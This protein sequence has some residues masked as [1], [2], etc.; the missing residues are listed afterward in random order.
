MGNRDDGD[1]RRE[2]KHLTWWQKAQRDAFVKIMIM[3]TAG[4]A[5]WI[6]TDMQ[7]IKSDFKKV[8]ETQI[9]RK[10]NVAYAGRLSNGDP[11]A[12]AVLCRN[13]VKDADVCR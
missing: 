10:D 7:T 3:V 13:M 4:M 11:Q 5:T 1:D 6:A 2:H 9:S 12:L 8:N